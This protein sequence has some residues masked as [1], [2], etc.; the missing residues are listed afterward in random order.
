MG[1]TGW[2]TQSSGTSLSF[3]WIYFIDSERGWAV[4]GSGII[5]NTTNGGTD[6]NP[7]ASGTSNLLYGVYFINPNIGWASGV[8]G[9]ILHTTNGGTTWSLQPGPTGETLNGVRFVDPNIGW[10]VGRRGTILNTT[11]GGTT[12][13]AQTS[14][15][16]RELVS[17]SFIDSNTGWVVGD[18]GV[19]LHTTNGG[20]TWIHQSSGTTEW[21][22]GV[23]FTDAQT[24]WGVGTV[25]T[26]L[27]TT[28]AGSTWTT[29]QSGVIASLL[30]VCFTDSHNGWA[31]G[32]DFDSGTGYI[33]HTSN[34][35]ATWLSQTHDG[36]AS[37]GSVHFVDSRTGWVAGGNGSILHTTDGGT[38][39]EPPTEPLLI[40]PDN[41]SIISAS[42]V[43]SWD[44]SPT[45]DW[46]TLQVSSTPFFT[47]NHLN[48]TDINGR[49]YQVSNLQADSPYY[50]RVSVTDQMGTSGWSDVWSF[51]PVEVPCGVVS[52]FNAKCNAA[53]TA[54]AIV[55][56]PNSTEYAGVSFQIQIDE[57]SYPVVL[58]TNG[59]HT[60]GRLQMPMAGFGQHTVL[61]ANPA[62]CFGPIT[63]D[64]QI[65][66]PSDPE[67]DILWNEFA[68]VAGGTSESDRGQ[69]KL[70]GA[71]PNPF[72]PFVTLRYYLNQPGNLT[73]KIYDVSGE[74]VRTTLREQQLAGYHETLWDGRNES[75]MAMASGVYIARI[76]SENMFD[77]RKIVLMK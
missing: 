29:Q 35:G 13:L 23:S 18:S 65:Q 53:G 33:L 75:G 9:T 17:I 27:H 46:H 64:C 6:W 61:L 1:G 19:V 50:W 15:T 30:S 47:T 26:I 74:L 2:T 37:L 16:A 12:W 44:S 31:V 34:S 4:G 38:G 52:S 45:A 59:T 63:I 77:M 28:N 3:R 76:E 24:G 48:E 69:L 57:V 60:I 32:A 8:M 70:T 56:L 71:F 73:M 7:Q 22:E 36:E 67:W 14:R 51:T 62:D 66:T 54:Q 58:M 43:F 41:G 25:G 5:L 20:A 55:R 72:N 68:A 49:S 10:A 42:P 11:N 21:I 39:I 40:S